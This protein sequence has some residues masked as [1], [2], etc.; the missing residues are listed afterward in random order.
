V[1]S[2]LSCEVMPCWLHLN[3]MQILD[4]LGSCN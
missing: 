2:G 1:K 3:V 4:H